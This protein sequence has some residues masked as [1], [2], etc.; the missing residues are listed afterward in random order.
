MIKKNYKYLFLV[1]SVVFFQANDL[2][3]RMMAVRVNFMAG[4]VVQALP[5]LLISGILLAAA[6]KKERLL[7]KNWKLFL[8]YGVAQILLGNVLYFLSMKWGGI[9]IASP[10]VQSQAVWAVI[11]GG[12]VIGEKVNKTAVLG[13]VCFAA[14]IAGL[15]FFKAQGMTMQE[16]WQWGVMFGLLAGL[17][18]ASA[19]VTQKLLIN[20][21]VSPFQTLFFGY[22][23][24]IVL[25]G[26]SGLITGG[27]D[28]TGAFSRPDTYRMLI[29]GL[30]SSFATLSF[31]HS[32][33]KIPVSLAVPVLSI[34]IIFNTLSGWIFW[35]EQMSVA[36]FACLLAALAGIVLSQNKNKT[37][38]QGGIRYGR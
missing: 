21:G 9:S 15:T 34:N 24:G 25:L 31:S 29:A 5:L 28:F 2:T 30:F 4:S 7:K 19:S 10:T 35:K 22:L 16:G 20:N 27:A 6:P 1:L 36:I 8:I 17:C 26:S 12:T 37:G 32:L 38:I 14:A 33:K 11:I 23:T 3:M 13:I 18:W